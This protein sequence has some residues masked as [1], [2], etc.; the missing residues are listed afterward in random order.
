MP[1]TLRLRPRL[2]ALVL[3]AV[4]GAALAGAPEAF[5]DAL[6]PE[7]G[8]SSNANDIDT[9]YKWALAVAIV[10]LVGVEGTLL[11]TLLRFRARKGAVAQQIHGNTRLEIGWTVA[12]ALVLVVVTIVTFVQLNDIKDPARSGPGG[13]ESAAGAQFASVDQP[14]PPG[15]RPLNIIVEGRQFIW[16]YTYP[17]ADR[18][19]LNNV[20]SY[21]E[22]VVP[23]N[24][25]VTLDLR[26]T[27]V[28]HSWWI[29]KLGGKFD[30][31][32]GYRNQTWFKATREGTFTG[33][34]TELCGRGH[35]NMTARVR[36][37]SVPEYQAWLGQQRRDIAAARQAAARDRERYES[38]NEKPAGASQEEQAGEPG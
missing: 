7:S 34:C 13:L 24:T 22:M 18:N 21:E 8:P 36:V 14:Q 5:A 16:R 31:V 37:V 10:V 3:L 29:P 27:D 26:A 1:P 38:N 28:V 17:D 15:G 32:P 33:A 20:F 19:T 12:T 25:T 30:A 23:V 11:Y 4:A 35:A 2:W 6:S 9:L